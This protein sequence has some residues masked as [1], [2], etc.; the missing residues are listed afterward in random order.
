[1]DSKEGLIRLPPTL[2]TITVLDARQGTELLSGLFSGC[3]R[4]SW[5][6]PV[7]ATLTITTWE[8]ITCAASMTSSVN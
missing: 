6:G 7:G 3:L 5:P 4:S 2:K 1:M 8:V